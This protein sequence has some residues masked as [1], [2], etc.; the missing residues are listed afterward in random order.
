[1]SISYGGAQSQYAFITP[2]I[3]SKK[4]RMVTSEQAVKILESPAIKEALLNVMTTDLGSYLNQNFHEGINAGELE[5]YS[6]QFLAIELQHIYEDLPKLSRW[7]INQYVNKYDVMNL[8][9]ILRR[10]SFRISEPPIGI[11]LGSM[12]F[13]RRFHDLLK[14]ESK[15]EVVLLLNSLSMSKYAEIVENGKERIGLESA[16]EVE[17]F[18]NLVKATRRLGDESI[19]Q[20]VG[21]LS[22]MNNVVMILR[23]IIRKKKVTLQQLLP[24]RY[25]FSSRELESCCKCNSLDEFLRK[26]SETYYFGL[27]AR[28]Q[29]SHELDNDPS[30]LEIIVNQ[31]LNSVAKEVFLSSAF[32]P[33]YALAYVLIRENEVKLLSTALKMIEEQVPSDK[34]TDYLIGERI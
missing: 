29:E 21:T 1:M 15:E 16:L 22:D 19:S 6:W 32:T 5:Y 31:Y 25:R 26:L 4:L 9:A 2:I 23:G 18:S 27:A 24:N 3:E 34:Y 13:K 10:I 11:P 14:C 33:G 30:L 12:Y 17:Y 20:F 8:K 7:I 28:L